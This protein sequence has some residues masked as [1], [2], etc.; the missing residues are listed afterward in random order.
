[1]EVL[2][3]DRGEKAGFMF[4]DADLIGIPFRVVVSPKTLADGEVEFK[5][6]GGE[7]ASRLKLADAAAVVAAG[8]RKAL[9][10]LNF[11]L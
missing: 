11:N 3:D 4:N 9:D 1:L 8:V 10:A 2:L 6:R 5:L 7:T